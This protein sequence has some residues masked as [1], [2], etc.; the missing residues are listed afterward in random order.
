MT[1]RTAPA[2][3]P[4]APST[5]AP[6]SPASARFRVPGLDGLR[7]LAVAVVIVFHLSPGALTGGYLGVDV[8][9]VIS[10]FIITALLGIAGAVVG[11]FIGQ[12]LGL[13]GPGEAAGFLMST[14]G[15]VVLLF[16][17]HKLRRPT[18]VRQA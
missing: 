17:Y 16:L 10:G 18:S 6:A 4:T 3:A 13:Y 9:F 14:I 8:F 1:S 12:A 5:A 2:P 15:A 7:A 11:G